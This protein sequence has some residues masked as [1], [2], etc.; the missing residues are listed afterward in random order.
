MG[1][2]EWPVG[3]ERVISS[4]N[5]MGW[6]LSIYVAELRVRIVSQRYFGV[7]YF[8][9]GAPEL[10]IYNTSEFLLALFYFCAD[11]FTLFGKKYKH[12]QC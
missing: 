10:E 9:F 11:L 4:S 3:G 1:A 6:W 7:R 5:T 12:T 2:F 8:N